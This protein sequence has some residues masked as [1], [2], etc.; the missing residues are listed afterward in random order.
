MA[1][2]RIN[3]VDALRGQ[4]DQLRRLIAQKTLISAAPKATLAEMEAQIGELKRLLAQLEKDIQDQLKR[5]P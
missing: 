1:E 4:Q 3:M 2:T 5:D